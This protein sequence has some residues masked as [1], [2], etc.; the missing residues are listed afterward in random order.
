MQRQVAC[1]EEIS[2]LITANCVK[3]NEDKMQFIWLG[4]PYQLFK[5]CFQI[6]TLGD[7]VIQISTKALSGSVA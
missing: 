1:I 3:L 5:F 4:T 7:V 6:V 2:E